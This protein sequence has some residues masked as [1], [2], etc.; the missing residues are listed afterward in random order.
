VVQQGMCVQDRTA[1]RYHWLSDKVK[2]FVVEP[3]NAIVGDIKRQLVLDM[4]A[5]ESDG[6]R[7]TSV[8]IAK[9]SPR[10]LMRM[11]VSVRP[12]LQKSLSEWMPATVDTAIRR[13][14][15]G[16]LSM[17]WNI[18]WKTMQKVYEFQ[19]N[20]YEELLGFKGVGRATVRGLR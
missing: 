4:T 5:K 18:N 8:D 6:S 15:P 11:V 7:R 1:R 14:P 19:P 17:P 13:Q 16:F 2:Q 12:E 10:R 3:H 9:E 20:N